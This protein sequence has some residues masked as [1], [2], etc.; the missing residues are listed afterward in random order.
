MRK[1]KYIVW[2]S[3][4]LLSEPMLWRFLIR[5]FHYTVLLVNIF[6]LLSLNLKLSDFPWPHLPRSAVWRPAPCDRLLL[7]VYL[8]AIYRILFPDRIS[9]WR[10][11]LTGPLWQSPS[12]L[13][14][15]SPSAA[16][17][18]SN[19]SASPNPLYRLKNHLFREFCNVGGCLW[20]RM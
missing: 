7:V 12:C 19:L 15:L 14:R 16:S 5:K 2:C 4:L 20:L 17:S 11:C 13:I 8:R 6:Y 1:I 3:V 10:S 18:P 9:P